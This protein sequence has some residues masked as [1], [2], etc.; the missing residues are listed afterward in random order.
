VSCFQ[1]EPSSREPPHYAVGL[2]GI[3]STDSRAHEVLWRLRAPDRARPANCS[4]HAFWRSVS[5]VSG[6]KKQTARVERA[7]HPRDLAHGTMARVIAGNCLRP[8][9]DTGCRIVDSHHIDPAPC[10]SGGGP[11]RRKIPRPWRPTTTSSAPASRMRWALARASSPR[12]RARQA[13][14]AGT[15]VSGQPAARAVTSTRSAQPD[16]PTSPQPCASAPP[17]RWCRRRWL[18]VFRRDAPPHRERCIG[19]RRN[20]LG[21][22]SVQP[23]QSP[24]KTPSVQDVSPSGAGKCL[25][26]PQTWLW[27]VGDRSRRTKVVQ[28]PSQPVDRA[29]TSWPRIPGI[30]TPLRKVSVAHN[31]IVESTRRSPKQAILNLRAGPRLARRTSVEA[32]TS[33]ARSFRRSRHA[34][35]C[36]QSAS[37]QP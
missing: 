36:V 37:S 24:R 22:S 13:R 8:P 9:R 30:A 10:R 16:L 7:R 27:M 12:V 29:A 4:A 2:G 11:R 21:I 18:P 23:C 34:S 25:Q 6:R 33:G 28:P 19:H 14:R 3:L 35:D 32:M 26:W 1:H 5:S 15:H 20:Q 17:C 31:D